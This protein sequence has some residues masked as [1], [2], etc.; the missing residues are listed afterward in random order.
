MPTAFQ[1]L[2]TGEALEPLG[3]PLRSII[4]TLPCSPSAHMTTKAAF[5]ST[6]VANYADGAKAVIQ[7]RD[8]RINTALVGL[9]HGKL[10]NVVP[11]VC[12]VT[13]TK[14][15][16]A[17]GMPFIDGSRWEPLCE[18]SLKD[19]ISIA[20]HLGSLLSNLK[21]DLPS[22]EVLVLS[23]GMPDL[24]N[25]A[26]LQSCI[27]RLLSRAQN[28]KKL[29]LTLCHADLHSW[30]IIIDNSTP[31]NI[32]GLIDWESITLLTLWYERIPNFDSIAVINR[33]LVD[34]P[35]DDTAVPIALAFWESLTAHITSSE[36]KAAVVDSMCIGLILGQGVPEPKMAQNTLARLD[37]LENI[38]KPLCKS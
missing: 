19:D 35:E 38:Y 13:A 28:L 36:I 29:P 27:E 23:N 3:Q 15:L 37:W 33:Q 4:K 25:A 22:D 8:S 2:T 1:N 30:N 21:L 34:Y 32:A 10:G 5:S 24:E 31:R 7:I 11:L 9:A 14:S 20:A 16:F 12:A 26:L 18:T 6:F 17:Y